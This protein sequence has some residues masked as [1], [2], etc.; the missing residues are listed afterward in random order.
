[1]V[2]IKEP[3]TVSIWLQGSTKDRVLKYVTFG[4][5]PD[6]VIQMLLKHYEEKLENDNVKVQEIPKDS[7]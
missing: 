1:M 2:N 6:D 3:V 4:F 5:K 7:V